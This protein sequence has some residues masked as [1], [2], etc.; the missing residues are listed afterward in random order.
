M[1]IVL[2]GPVEARLNGVNLSLAPLERSLLALLALSPRT[3]QSTERIIDGIWGNN[4]PAAPRSRV[5]GLVSTLRRKLGAT[6]VTRNPG[7]LLDLPLGASDLDRCDDLVRQAREAKAIDEAVRL[8]RGALDL[9]RGDPLDGVTAPGA[10]ADRIRLAE[11]RTT[12]TEECFEAELAL[13]RHA[14]LISDLVTAVAAHPLRERLTGQLMVALYRANRQA[15]AL[16]AYQT[17]QSRLA[18]ELGSDPCA[19]LRA[20]HLTILRGA[21]VATAAAAAGPTRV[22]PIR[23]PDEYRPA[24]MPASVGHFIG[25]D[26]DLAA[27]TAA[28]P[29]P[30]DEPRILLVSA[31]GGLG[32]TALAVRWAHSVADRFPDG[33]IFVDLRGSAAGAL[34]PGAALGAVL[35]AL[36]LGPDALPVSVAERAALYRTMAHGKRILLVADDAA[37][38]AQLLPLVPPT[39]GSL[40]MVTSRNRLA[41]L[42]VHHAVRTVA[43]EPLPA[44]AARGLLSEIVGAE[45][46]RADGAAEVV[47]LCGGWPLVIRLAGATLAARSRQSLSSFA[48][49]LKERV[50]VLSV[51]DDPR[52]VRAALTQAHESLDPPAARLFDQLGVLPGSSV[53]LELAAAAAGTS[54]LRAR[55]LLD[56]LISANLVVETGRDRYWFHEM[57]WRYARRRGATLT[58]RPVVEERVTRWYLTTFDAM[59]SGRTADDPAWG[60]ESTPW[61]PPEGEDRQGFRQAETANLP[62]VARWVAARGHADLTWQLISSAHSAGFALNVETGELGLAA[63]RKLDD[64]RILGAAYAHLG[65][66]LVREP[67]RDDEA[68][69][70]LTLAT[71]L[72]DADDPALAGVATFALGGL[73]AGQGRPAEARAVLE[74]TLRL[75]DPAIQPMS[76]VVAL[77]G[78]ADVL[79][80]SGGTEQ[81]RGRFA[82]ALILAEATVAGR[83]DAEGQ[84]LDR[85]WAD[86]FLGYLEAALPGPRVT[87]GDRTLAAE[88]IDLSRALRSRKPATVAALDSRPAGSRQ[89]QRAQAM[90]RYLSL[91]RV[92]TANSYRI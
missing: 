76:Y 84:P 25:R 14:D 47:Q 88:L 55:M 3:V 78:Y 59:A 39:A 92:D 11:Q 45:R 28:L 7:Y 77:F 36:G 60:P 71:E 27:L 66:A 37:S 49:E 75:L 5:Q 4:P 72:L 18:E 31:A 67:L 52:T 80:R 70:H 19:D 35:L 38:V 87:G 54:V 50:D 86:E 51:A 29:G 17:L 65:S 30:E 42:T 73:L 16:R 61:P 68:C 44:A 46:L 83:F 64:R 74:R 2:L 85:R 32:K 12:L 26:A 79:A 91:S 41:A 58:D 56:Q 82:Q 21:P 6:L 57:I 9:W 69:A 40:I 48:Q 53:S 13:G 43:I 81:S 33:Q 89:R 24:Q 34:S 10:D 22:D 63:A 23:P 8:L 20:L 1:E 90:G 62:A 15:E